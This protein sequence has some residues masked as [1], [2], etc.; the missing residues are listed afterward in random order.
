MRFKP[1]SEDGTNGIPHNVEHLCRIKR[2]S[3]ISQRGWQA[4]EK[5][6][7][8]R[9]SGSRLWREVAEEGEGPKV[10]RCGERGN[11]HV[12]RYCGWEA[13]GNCCLRISSAGG[14]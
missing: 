5:W 4:S 3:A 9:E 13:T 10:L 8:R 2:R 6:K 14:Q 11:P 12:G 1:T 7:V